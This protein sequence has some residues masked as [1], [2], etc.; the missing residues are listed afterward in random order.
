MRGRKPNLTI[1]EGNPN[2]GPIPSPPSMLDDAAKA[3]WKRVAPILHE[4]GHLDDGAKASLENYCRCVSLCR[5]YSAM[6]DRDG[7]VI[8]GP[9][10]PKKHPAFSMLTTVMSE[11]RRL[12]SELAISPARRKEVG[13]AHNQSDEWD[14]L[15]A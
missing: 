1:V 12:A 7:H 9:S 3:E 13:K 10:G 2:P 11:Q 14:D 15:L 6:L 5:A 8:E 4:R